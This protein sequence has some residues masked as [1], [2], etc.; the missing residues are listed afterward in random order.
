VQL[1]TR[2]FNLIQ[3]QKE[4]KMKIDWSTVV[5]VILAMLLYSLIVSPLVNKVLPE[6]VLGSF[7]GEGEI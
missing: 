5:S 1:C 2:F 7:E 3:T 4:K 6:G